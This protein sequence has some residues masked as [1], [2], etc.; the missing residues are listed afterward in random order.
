MFEIVDADWINIFL[1]VRA[2]NVATAVSLATQQQCAET[3]NRPV[4]FV[5]RITPQDITPAQPQTVE[6]EVAVPTHQ[7]IV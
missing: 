6:E 3:K 1:L 5:E 7:C 4:V 2:L